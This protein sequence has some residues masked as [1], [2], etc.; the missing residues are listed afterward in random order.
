[1][2]FTVTG[3]Q[4]R[5]PLLN[6]AILLFLGYMLLL[7][8][9]NAL[10]FFAEMDL[11]YQSV[12]DYYRGNAENYTNPRSYEGMLEVAHF[13]MF[14]MGVFVL[15][16]VHLVLF[17]ELSSRAKRFWLWTPFLFAVGNEAA[18]W[19]VR[20]AGEPFAYLKLFTFVG[21]ELSLLGLMAII[22]WSLVANRRGGYNQGA[23]RRRV[24]QA[25]A[26]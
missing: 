20:F 9:S 3:E 16:L 10:M 7:W 12:V 26:G 5:N 4:R 17:A 8:V 15:T 2:R 11:T 23:A 18:G 14:A 22:L 6:T 24:S 21:L 13:H 1:M 25:Q 19:L